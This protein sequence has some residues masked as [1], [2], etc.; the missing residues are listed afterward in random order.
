[1][2][3]F[4]EELNA[5]STQM[6]EITDKLRDVH[7]ERV[8]KKFDDYDSEV[9]KKMAKAGK[10]NIKSWVK[11]IDDHDLIKKPLDIEIENVLTLE[12]KQLL[13][14]QKNYLKSQLPTL[15]RMLD[16][17]ANQIHKE[18]FMQAT[19][20]ERN[21]KN[22]AKEVKK[23][24]KEIRNCK[25]KLESPQIYMKIIELLPKLQQLEEYDQIPV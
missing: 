11:S 10:K 1:M 19:N 24:I 4:G 5:A 8:W 12:G 20:L 25:E 17:M 3:Q 14:W 18:N 23:L 15:E 9:Y 21:R 2:Q 13:E 22:L 7:K 16:S 6:K